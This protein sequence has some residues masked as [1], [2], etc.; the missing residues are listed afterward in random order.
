MDQNMN[1]AINEA[2]DKLG[3]E[4][5]KEIAEAVGKISQNIFEKG[6][7]P[8]DAMG[9]SDSM[10][11]G[12]YGYAYRL[13]N[14]GKY[15]DASHL[16]RILIMLNPTESKYILGLAACQHMQ[17]DYQNAIASY[18]FVGLIDPY[19]PLPHYHIS[20]CYLKTNLPAM[21][22]SELEQA[23]EKCGRK[24]QY[25]LVKERAALMLESL[26]Q[27]KPIEGIPTPEMPGAT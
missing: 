5:S 13:Y 26:E 19:N 11:E 14:S 25:A 18:A 8:K 21:A 15:K 24:P 7:L 22:Q 12:I 2:L 23:V 10:V 27:G 1:E 20:D 17:Q 4:N 3:E 16:F 6:M 9:L